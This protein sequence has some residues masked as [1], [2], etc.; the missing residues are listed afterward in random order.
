MK[1]IWLSHY[2]KS[3]LILTL[4]TLM[5]PW[6]PIYVPQAQAQS[7]GERI[8]NLFR[9][10][11]KQGRPSGRSRG[12]AIRDESCVP[13]GSKP[14]TALVPENE[15]GTTIA[16]HPTFWF[17]LPVGRSEKV[18]QA[19]FSL[20]DEN[21]NLVL[22]QKMA[23]PD[24]PGIVSVKL[25]ETEQPLEVG[26][27]YKWYFSIICD[28]RQPSRNPEVWGEV[29]RVKASP[30]LVRQLKTLPESEQY[31]AFAEHD[32]SQEALTQLA[33]HRSINSDAWMALLEDFKLKDVAN[34]AITQLSPSA[35]TRRD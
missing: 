11:R 27:Q 14:L 23:L 29:Q 16:A 34:A 33:L 17:Y 32:I 1:M 18:T 9:R 28:E 13:K 26:K 25:P 7:V 3:I 6:L 20:L 22:Q 31:I 21:Q 30:E 35:E 15:P 12:G 2:R 5:L 19:E 4:S 8:L 10:D 24:A